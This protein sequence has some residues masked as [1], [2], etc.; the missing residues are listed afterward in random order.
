[1]SRDFQV[2]F[3]AGDPL[4]QARF[5]AAALGYVIPGPPGVTLAEAEDPIEAWMGFL[6]SAGVPADQRDRAS[7]IEDP[8]GSRPRSSSR[9]CR[10]G[11]WPRTASISTSVGLPGCRATNG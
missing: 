6:A 11:R 9:R 3:D 8:D 10:K 4:G 7:A 5:W 1:M 2:T